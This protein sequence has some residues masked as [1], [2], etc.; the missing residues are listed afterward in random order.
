MYYVFPYPAN[1]T[2]QHR[3]DTASTHSGQA[4]SGTVH[5]NYSGA[6]PTDLVKTNFMIKVELLSAGSFGPRNITP[7]NVRPVQVGETQLPFLSPA[8]F[9]RAKV[10]AW[11]AR[12]EEKDL[13]DIHDAMHHFDTQLTV[14]DFERPQAG[15]QMESMIETIEEDTNRSA[16]IT[17]KINEIKRIHDR[18]K[19]QY[20]RSPSPHVHSNK[21]CCIVS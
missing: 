9:I 16:D 5:P 8:E 2:Q 21:C 7:E 14:A 17:A 1:G 6:N 4:G 20:N 10:N 18:L 13:T 12:A 19:T 11:N 15:G 3:A